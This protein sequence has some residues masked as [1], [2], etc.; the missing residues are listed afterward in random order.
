MLVV[1]IQSRLGF[2]FLKFILLLSWYYFLSIELQ[3]WS[4][5]EQEKVIPQ[6]YL[7]NIYN[8]IYYIFFTLL[9]TKMNHSNQIIKYVL[10]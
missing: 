5:Q 3:K 4:Y 2:W 6:I 10:E 1:D 8:S 9:I 7:N